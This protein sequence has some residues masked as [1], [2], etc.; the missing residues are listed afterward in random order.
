MLSSLSL[1]MTHTQGMYFILEKYTSTVVYNTMEM[2][3][4][5]QFLEGKMLELEPKQIH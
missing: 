2:R 5:S 1:D 3:D 4:V